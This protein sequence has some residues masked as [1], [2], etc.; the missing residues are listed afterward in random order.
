M[1]FQSLNP[2]E[3]KIQTLNLLIKK[4]KMKIQPLIPVTS[5]NEIPISEPSGGEDSNSEPSDK[6]SENEDL[7]SCSWI[8]WK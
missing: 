6:E 1:K 8:I 7:T 4:V 5:V 3:G 2:L